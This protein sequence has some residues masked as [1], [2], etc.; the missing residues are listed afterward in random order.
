MLA[1]HPVGHAE[2]LFPSAT[3]LTGAA[4]DARLQKHAVARREAQDAVAQ[5]VYDSGPVAPGD[6]R[7]RHVGYA[8]AYE[9]IEQEVFRESE[10][11]PVLTAHDGG[12]LAVQPHSPRIRHRGVL[13][14]HD[15]FTASRH[16]HIPLGA[17]SRA[18]R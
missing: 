5:P 11:E 14:F 7:Q 4:E 18:L 2:T 13:S 8:V 12:N 10:F 17:T 16:R 3:E 9:E 1:Q 15:R 6:L